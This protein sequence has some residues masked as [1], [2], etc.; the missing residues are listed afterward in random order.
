MAESN[1]S[2]AVLESDQ[3]C[4]S[5]PTEAAVAG[6]SEDDLQVQ[7][8]CLLDDLSMGSDNVDSSC[9]LE[10]EL[11]GEECELQGEDSDD[12][13]RADCVMESESDVGD[14][15]DGR[16]SLPPSGCALKVDQI[17]A[18]AMPDLPHVRCL[19]L[20]L[21][22]TCRIDARE[23]RGRFLLPLSS[24]KIRVQKVYGTIRCFPA[25]HR[26]ASYLT[27]RG[28][29]ELPQQWFY[30]PAWQR[31]H[32]LV[33]PCGWWVHPTFAEWLMGLP[34]GWTHTQPLNRGA[35]QSHPVVHR[36]LSGFRS[37]RVLSLF[38]GAG[39]LDFGLW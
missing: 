25:T 16:R 7:Q 34:R 30:D 32:P 23:S 6:D 14:V 36:Q 22:Q 27:W 1:G 8:E 3:D 12:G 35:L 5:A 33:N 39:A 4:M 17:R 13:C 2:E 11:Q 24:S 20:R 29:R 9:Q 38:S 31:H 37:M 26:V 15:V 28:F 10:C 18:I 21:E 19:D